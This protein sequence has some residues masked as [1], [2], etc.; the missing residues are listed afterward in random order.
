MGTVLVAHS[1]PHSPRANVHRGAVRHCD[2]GALHPDDRLQWG[3]GLRQHQ[4]LPPGIQWVP[5]AR[6]WDDQRRNR[7][8]PVPR[9]PNDGTGASPH[10]YNRARPGMHHNANRATPSNLSARLHLA[11]TAGPRSFRPPPWRPASASR[12][13]SG[14]FG[15]SAARASFQQTPRKTPPATNGN[16][17]ARCL[18]RRAARVRGGSR[19]PR[20]AKPQEHHLVPIA[21]PPRPS[22]PPARTASGPPPR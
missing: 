17:R 14:R 10:P 11:G 6:V 8:H 2:D 3:G 5:D 9:L 19:H 13:C 21:R 15:M 7:L 1:P 12:R 18:D 16:A 20:P 4:Q 22:A